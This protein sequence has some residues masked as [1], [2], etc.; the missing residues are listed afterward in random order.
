MSDLERTTPPPDFK[1][2][3]RALQGSLAANKEAYGHH[4]GDVGSKESFLE[5]KQGDKYRLNATAWEYLLPGHSLLDEVKGI[6]LDWAKP[7]KGTMTVK[8]VYCREG[9]KEKAH[10]AFK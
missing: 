5:D 2:I 1:C 8:N 10:E 3:K 7:Y 6:D 4:L 9:D